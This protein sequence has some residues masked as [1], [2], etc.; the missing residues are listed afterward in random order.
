[1]D[2]L[3]EEQWSP[4][5]LVGTVYRAQCGAQYGTGDVVMT[6]HGEVGMVDFLLESEGS[7]YARIEVWRELRYDAARNIGSYRKDASNKYVPCSAIQR[8]AIHKMHKDICTALWL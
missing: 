4:P 7:E 6:T 5:L 1:M 8:A 3:L 2:E